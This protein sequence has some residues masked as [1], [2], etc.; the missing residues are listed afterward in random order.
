MFVK[1]FHTITSNILEKPGDGAGVLDNIETKD[2]QQT[3]WY[4]ALAYMPDPSPEEK[5]KD[6]TMHTARNFN[7]QIMKEV[8]SK[9]IL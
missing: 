7:N 3:V 6:I 5:C 8:I 9:H 2:I 4:V 1:S